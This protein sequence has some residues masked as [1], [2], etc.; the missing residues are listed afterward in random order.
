MLKLK[1]IEIHAGSN[2]MERSETF[3][4]IKALLNNPKTTVEDL[5]EIIAKDQVLAGSLL[6]FIK[7]FGFPPENCTLSRAISLLGYD[8]LRNIVL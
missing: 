8:A 6:H 4:K 3:Y 7:S 5:S 2:N 1:S